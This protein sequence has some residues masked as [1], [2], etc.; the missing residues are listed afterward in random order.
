MDLAVTLNAHKAD[1]VLLDT[2]DSIKTFVTNDVIVVVDGASWS[3]FETF[4]LPVSKFEGFYHNSSKDPYRNMA[5]GL[6]KT[7]ETYPNKDWY[8]YTEYD[9]L[10][11]NDTFKNDLKI[12][13]DHNIWCVGNDCKVSRCKFS[14]IE[15]H[16]KMD[17]KISYHLIGCCMFLHH[18]FMA[19]LHEINFFERFL[20]LTNEF[21][22]G[23]PLPG[24]TGQKIYDLSEDLYP[25]LANYFGGKVWQFAA[26]YEFNDTWIGNYKKYPMR[27]TP[28]I[29]EI[30]PEAS[31]IHPL[32]SYDN[33]VREFCRIKRE[34]LKAWQKTNV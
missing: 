32:K 18:N 22:D 21:G 34:R 1:N 33:P 17:F 31:I 16:F 13:K 6:K 15:N 28:E 5:L 3:Q 7:Y 12:A 24:L 30:D 26:W 29:T 14:L 27:F 8:C 2:L 19:K 10:F 20:Y 25:T 23:R 4:P 11:A 9:C